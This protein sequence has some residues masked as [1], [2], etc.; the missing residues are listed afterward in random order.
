VLRIVGDQWSPHSHALRET[1]SRNTI[2]YGF[3]PSDS[4]RGRELIAAHRVDVARLPR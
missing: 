3:Y 4:E 1:M 2:P